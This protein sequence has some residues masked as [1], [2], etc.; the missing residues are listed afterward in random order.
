MSH[1]MPV[2]AMLAA[3]VAGGNAQAAELTLRG[4]LSG[5]Q[6]ISAT[7]SP[8]TGEVRA[9]LEDDNDLRL[10]MAYAGLTA[11]ATGAG[12][13]MGLDNENGSR[14]A[15][16]DIALDSTEGRFGPVTLALSP[17]VAASVR[18]GEAYAVITTLGHPDGAIRAQ[19]RPQPP[20]APALDEPPATS[21]APAPA[22][23]TE[24][25]GG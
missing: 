4:A 23:S 25:P 16:L 1:R 11:G 15:P 20:Q 9:V 10:E 18:A 13:Y 8:A 22:G 19:L 5:T 3:L 2:A 6:V 21:G 24:P 7:D 12:L 14:V 17:E